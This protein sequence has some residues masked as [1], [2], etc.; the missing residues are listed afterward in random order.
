MTTYRQ[1]KGYSIKSV[2][3]DPSNPKEGQ[4]WYN[5]TVKTLKVSPLFTTG[6]WSSGANLP[7]AMDQ[8]GSSRLGTQTAMAIFGAGPHPSVSADTLE[9]DGT[10]WTT[11]ND[12]NTGRRLVNCS[13]GTLT[14]ALAFGGFTP[15]GSP[16]M[17]KNTEEYNGTSWT[18]SNNL[19]GS[20]K[21]NAG[22]SGTQT[23]ALSC[24]GN[25]NPPFQLTETE[26]YNGSSW[27]SGGNLNSGRTGGGSAG[28]QT[29]SLYA[30]GTTQNATEEYNGSSWSEVNDL[31]E[32]RRVKGGGFGTQTAA[33][34][35][36]GDGHSPP[37][38][39]SAG[40]CEQYDGT[41]FSTIANLGS[42]FYER[43]G[44]GAGTTTAGILVSG[45]PAN[46]I[47]EEWN[48]P[49]PRI[50]VRSVDVS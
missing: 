34:M 15:P 33:I 20:A 16:G 46:N 3:S 28:T 24:G 21:Y 10:N 47:T 44:G 23:S 32:P 29:A 9:Y 50:E 1:V 43:R 45:G 40:V 36:G 13:T 4:I 49:S 17:V 37:N 27:T 18:N 8:P 19:S 42:N 26:E 5:N 41:N 38:P 6:A 14:A 22:G 39:S 31:N 2:S 30:G 7:Q 48:D 35:A 25:A 11:S 12:L